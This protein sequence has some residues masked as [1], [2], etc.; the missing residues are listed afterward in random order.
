MSQGYLR[1]EIASLKLAEEA[2][3][4][5]FG[6][7]VQEK[8]ELE[9]QIRVLQDTIATQQKIIQQLNKNIK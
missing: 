9:A 2:A 7:V 3:K 5:V 8:R 6:I 4:E 1:A